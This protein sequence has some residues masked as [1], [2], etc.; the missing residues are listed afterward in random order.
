MYDLRVVL[1]L[2]DVVSK[3]AGALALRMLKNAN[4]PGDTLGARKFEPQLVPRPRNATLQPDL[5]VQC[6]V[7][8][9]AREMGDK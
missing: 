2:G 1:M 4:V 9:P 7:F 5:D 3:Q 6:V 8:F